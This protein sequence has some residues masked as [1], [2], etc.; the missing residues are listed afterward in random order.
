MPLK[1][2]GQQREVMHGVAGQKDK[3]T[4]YAGG[5]TEI[6]VACDAALAEHLHRPIKHVG[7]PL[8]KHLAQVLQAVP[9]QHGAGLELTVTRATVV[10]DH[11]KGQ[12]M[13]QRF[14]V[15]NHMP[16]VRADRPGKRWRAGRRT[17]HFMSAHHRQRLI[18]HLL[19][20][21]Q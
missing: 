7:P 9:G 1:V 4:T 20:E 5:H 13:D 19:V 11:A 16:Q 3:L 10:V 6:E 17:R 15:L 8:A 12:A 2:C 14:I 18:D 21:A